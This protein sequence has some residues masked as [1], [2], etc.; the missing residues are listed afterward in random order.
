M[1]RVNVT[2]CPVLKQEVVIVEVKCDGPKCKHQLE[3]RRSVLPDELHALESIK[4]ACKRHTLK[5]AAKDHH[6]LVNERDDRHHCD[7]C[8]AK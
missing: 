7:A 2:R 4:N 3:Y 8:A 1:L 6:W 5:T